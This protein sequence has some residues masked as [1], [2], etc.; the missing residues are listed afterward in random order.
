MA[1][2]RG[3]HG[4]P[5]KW[6]AGREVPRSISSNTWCA[7]AMLGQ[8]GS[9]DRDQACPGVAEYA[10]DRT[11]GVH[12]LCPGGVRAKWIATKDDRG[13]ADGARVLLGRERKSGGREI[14]IL[15]D[16]KRRRQSHGLD[17]LMGHQIF[18]YVTNANSKQNTDDASSSKLLNDDE[19]SPW[20][21]LT[22][23]VLLLVMMQLGVVDFFAFSRVCKSWR[24]LALTN[25]KKLMASRPPMLM[26]HNPKRFKAILVF[27]RSL[28]EWVVVILGRGKLL[29]SIAGESL[30]VM[31]NTRYHPKQ[32]ETY[33]VYEVDLGEMKWV[34]CENTIGEYAFFLS[35]FN[36]ATA[37]KPQSWPAPGSQ[38]GKYADTG[39]SGKCNFFTTK[40]WKI[41]KRLIRKEIVD[42]EANVSNPNG[43]IVGKNSYLRLLFK[44]RSSFARPVCVYWVGK[45]LISNNWYQS[46]EDPGAAGLRVGFEKGL[47]TAEDGDREVVRVSRCRGESTGCDDGGTLIALFVIRGDRRSYVK[48]GRKRSVKA[49]GFGFGSFSGLKENG[50]AKT[51]SMTRNHI[52]D[53]ED[54]AST[55][56]RIQTWHNDTVAP[57]RVCKSWRSF[58]LPNKIR[59]MASK[60]PMELRISEGPNKRKEYSLEDFGGRSFKILLPKSGGRRCVGLTYG[61]LVLYGRKSCDFLLMNPITRHAICFPKVPTCPNPFYPNLGGLRAILVFSPSIFTWVLVVLR[62]NNTSIWFSIAGKGEWDYV[63]CNYV[64]SDLHEFKGKIYVIDTDSRLYEVGLDLEP[65]LTLL[66]TKNTLGINMMFRDFV[67]S[68]ENLYAMEFFYGYDYKVQK[69]DFG[70][71]KW[72]SPEDNPTEDCAFFVSD[73]NYSAAIKPGLWSESDYWLRY[74]YGR[75][76]G[77]IMFLKTGRCGS[78]VEETGETVTETK[79]R[80]K[81]FDFNRSVKSRPRLKFRHPRF[82]SAPGMGKRRGVSISKN[83]DDGGPWS[84]LNHDLLN[85]VMMKLETIDFPAFSTVCK[86]WRSLA[87]PNKSMFMASRPPMAL[88]ISERPYYRKEYSLEDL[89]GKMFKIQLPKSRGRYFVGLTC[90]YLVLYGRKSCDFMLLNPI[91]RHGIRFPKLPSAL[92]RDQDRVRAILVFSPSRSAWVFVVLCRF[93][94]KI[95]FSIAGKGEW[96]YV[97]SIFGIVDLHEFKGKI[98]ALDTES[99]LYE[100]RLDPEPTLMLL[101]TK[102]VLES[103]LM[104]LE[105]VS[106][107]E[108]LYAV[109][110][111]DFDEY[112]AHKLDFGEMKWVSQEE[113][114]NEEFAFFVSDL[115]HSAAFKPG[116]WSESDSWLRYNRSVSAVSDTGGNCMFFKANICGSDGEE[117]GDTVTER[118]H[119]EKS[120]TSTD[121]LNHVQRLKF[122]HP[123]FQSG[124]GKTRSMT[125]NHNHDDDD[126]SIGKRIDTSVA[127]WSELNH[128][129]LFLVMMEL[130][131]VDFLSF[132]GV[133]KSWRSLALPN[134][135]RF[136]ASKPPMELRI[137]EGPNKTKEY[138]LVDFGGRSFKIILPESSGWYCVGLTCGY[139]VFFERNSFDFL[140]INPNTRHAIRFPPVPCNKFYNFYLYSTRGGLRVILVFSPF[141]FTWVVVVLRRNT[142]NIWFSITGKGE[143]D[144]SSKSVISDLHE[145]KGKIYA[146]DINS[147]LYELRLNLEPKLMLLNS[148]NTF[149]RNFIFPEFVSSGENLYAMECFYGYEYK[150]YILDFGEM[151]WVSKEENSI[152]NFA[153]FVSDLRQGAAALKPGTTRVADFLD[154]NSIANPAKVDI[155]RRAYLW[156]LWNYRNEAVFKGNTQLVSETIE[157]EKQNRSDRRQP[158]SGAGEQQANNGRLL[159]V[160]GNIANGSS[161]S[162]SNWDCRSVLKQKLTSSSSSLYL[163]ELGMGKKKTHVSKIQNHGGGPPWSELNHDV[164]FSVMMELGVVDFV[165]FSGVCK[166][167]R[168][169]ALP[170]KIRFMA[171]KPPMELYWMGERSNKVDEYSL[172]DFEG[173]EF[174]VL[175]PEAASRACVGLTC[176]YLVLFGGYYSSFLLT[177]PITRHAIHFP[178]APDSLDSFYDRTRAGLRA[179]LVFS[180]SIFTW[181]LVVLR[182]N[183]TSIWF[184]I[185]GKGEWDYVSSNSVII[186]VHEFKGKIYAIDTKSRLYEVGLDPMPKLTL[187]KTKNTLGRKLMFQEFVSSGENLYAMECFSQYEYKVHKLDFGGMKWVSQ[188]EN[189]TEDHG[190]NLAL[191]KTK[192]VLEPDLVF[193]EFVSSGE[194]LYAVECFDFFEYEA[195]KFNFGEME[196]VS[197]ENKIGMEECAGSVGRK[198]KE[199]AEVE[200]G[201]RRLAACNTASGLCGVFGYDA[202]DAQ[203]RMAKT[204]SMTRNHKHD[205]DDASITK[206]IKTCHNDSVAPWSDLNHDLLIVVMLK[207][208]AIDFASFSGVCKPWRSLALSNKSMFMASRPPMALSVREKHF[209][210]KFFLE[211]LGGKM[212]KIQLP[213]TGGS[214]CAGV[215]CGYLVFFGA[216]TRI[217]L[218]LNPIT[219]HGICFPKVPSN[220]VPHKEGVRVILVFSPSTSLWVLVVVCRFSTKIWFSIAGKGEWD[221]VSSTFGIVDL[222]EFKG[223]IYALDTESCLYELRLDPK[224]TLMLLN[225]KNVLESDL[226][227]LEFVSSGENLYAVECFNF[228]RYKAHKLDF[229]EMKWVSL[230]ENP[231]ENYVFFVSDLK[232]SVAFKPGLWS[233]IA[234]MKGEI[235]KGFYSLLSRF[236]LFKY[237]L[238][239]RF[240]PSICFPP[241]EFSMKQAK[242]TETTAPV[243]PPPFS[244]NHRTTQASLLSSSSPVRCFSAS[245]VVRPPGFA[246]PQIPVGSKSAK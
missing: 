87:L 71:M 236:I 92:I 70:E 33:K 187:L 147:C 47:K 181:V 215:T 9:L 165:S 36:Q 123:R 110:G 26:S 49:G 192:N 134:K 138:S 55:G 107:G 233:E 101:N 237:A 136:M 106:S 102:N 61:Y 43:Y 222:H 15:E 104:F 149:G 90:G 48:N 122:R 19:Y 2:T 225:T 31:F 58:A 96:D 206:R 135:I 7:S 155:A 52:H 148:K 105:F 54:D 241:L 214:F 172:V 125:R 152:E 158:S 18:K 131:V 239:C 112:V 242:K 175:L 20:S 111:F 126:A 142:T 28:S 167:W 1:W 178:K 17:N 141:A 50:M 208:E 227:F 34:S 74:K 63:S 240:R 38:Y 118:N 115:K 202:D 156:V 82:Q 143:W 200:G 124:M 218:L 16:G 145:F 27:S 176:G 8:S 117:T 229:G 146:I 230:K 93:T 45:R 41:V 114:P 166:S 3:G 76:S 56:K 226:M 78:E 220:L 113:N 232:H 6:I 161:G 195:H 129:V 12:G 89:G 37:V 204:R 194:N 29:Y 238:Q 59:F 174:K 120:S 39:E 213:R 116:L 5:R 23:H 234:M 139:L 88:W 66:K 103:D 13:V 4:L 42:L 246:A 210:K 84:D 244:R 183:T 228:Y 53:D 108:N 22:H 169:L 173:R 157:T 99:C 212:F 154:S 150:V 235:E 44:R 190:R 60:P 98:Y 137:S 182:R 221:Y 67:S 132:S 85:L 216:K 133:C 186:D 62:R 219:R 119:G 189:T 32:P 203:Q 75:L 231:T 180:P 144:I 91:T 199:E 95:W 197:K 198:R 25:G 86:P 177:N 196:W 223:K 193:W 188:E 243:E 109:E 77:N 40:M 245:S 10:F 69:L 207:L 160:L 164:L 11:V 170:N 168:S 162:I 185:A 64:I 97:S 179:I 130:G 51:I 159:S 151:K 35:D 24:S 209:K 72:V 211:D 217:F 191:L 171:C 14:G 30:Y 140:L 153:F 46:G 121:L 128:D 184:S 65:K 81:I 68:D 21:D 73:W 201:G 224:P 163:F 100:L 94:S 83:R 127:P 57:C 79:S 80:R 205:D